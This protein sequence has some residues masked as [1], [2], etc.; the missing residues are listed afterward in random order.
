ME[1]KNI[2]FVWPGPC[3]VNSIEYSENK[4][5]YFHKYFNGALVGFASNK[6]KFISNVGG[7]DFHWLKHFNNPFLRFV[8][9]WFA[10]IK[11]LDLYYSKKCKFSVVISPNPL[12]TGVIA[13]I[14]GKLTRTKVVVEI[15]GNFESAFKYGVKGE[16]SSF[17]DK[18]KD[19]VAKQLIFFSCKNADAIKILNEKQLSMF[20][21]KRRRQISNVIRFP[22]FTATTPFVENDSS[23]NHYILFL[24]FPW[25]LKGVD[26]LIKAFNG[27]SNDYPD[28]KLKIVGWCP[29]GRDF[30]ENLANGNKQI[31]FLDPIA[32][33]LVPSIMGGCSL[34]VLPSRTEAMGRVLIEAMANRKPVI[35]SNV[36]GIPTIVKDNFNGLLFEK[37]NADELERKI[38]MILSNKEFAQSLANNAF[39]Y[40]QENLTENCFINNYKN[41]IDTLTEK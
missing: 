22:D 19:Y 35:G 1:K 30:F 31:E 40:V 10:V 7:F 39:N 37:E 3:F 34:F 36:D 11:A 15:N 29:E 33:N 16:V 8:Y 9:T 6:F 5:R 14:I 27:L 26:I 20:S 24:G 12:I 13:I 32:H 41:L 18:V 21:P 17:S 2:L 38:R 25:Y 28:Y 23:D 4:L